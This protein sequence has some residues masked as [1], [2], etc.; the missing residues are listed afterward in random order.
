MTDTSV[1]ATVNKVYEKKFWTLVL[2][3]PT[4]INL[5]DAEL[6]WINQHRPVRFSLVTV[7]PLH[8]YLSFLDTAIEELTQSGMYQDLVDRMRNMVEIW[9]SR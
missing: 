6:K 2:E 4:G 9:Y 3:A 8:K 1:K 7:V 5:F